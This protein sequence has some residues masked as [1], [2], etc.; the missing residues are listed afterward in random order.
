[1]NPFSNSVLA[2]FVLFSA[3]CIGAEAEPTSRP[4]SGPAGF[5]PTPATLSDR[6]KI[7]SGDLR[8][9]DDDL[10]VR[11]FPLKQTNVRAEIVET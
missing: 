10:G 9:M 3:A 7:S 11:S 2:G 5:E 8:V 6:G 1:M 4:A